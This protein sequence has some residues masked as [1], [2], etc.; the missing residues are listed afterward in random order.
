MPEDLRNYGVLNCIMH[1]TVSQVE[2]IPPVASVA[3][4]LSPD[5]LPS[6]VSKGSFVRTLSPWDNRWV[7]IVSFPSV[8][9]ISR[10]F[11]RRFLKIVRERTIQ[12]FAYETAN[13]FWRNFLAGVSSSAG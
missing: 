8:Y 7:V 9:G 5:K 12:C 11:V 1:P 2:E 3:S 4:C 6:D 10:R 13:A